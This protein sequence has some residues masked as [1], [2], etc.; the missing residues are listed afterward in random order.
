MKL[1]LSSEWVR[2]SNLTTDQKKILLDELNLSTWTK[3]ISVF[4]MLV[5]S[6]KDP[7]MLLASVDDKLVGWAAIFADCPMYA[8][9]TMFFVHP[10]FRRTKIATKLAEQARKL[11]TNVIIDRWS[12][13]AANFAEAIAA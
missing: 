6:N 10:D 5:E 7:L 1:E 3:Y 2:Y 11:N 12:K 8:S 9:Y 4:K 13:T